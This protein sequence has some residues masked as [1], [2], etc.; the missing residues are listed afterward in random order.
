MKRHRNLAPAPVAVV[1]STILSASCPSPRAGVSRNRV[2]GISEAVPIERAL[3]YVADGRG[4]IAS[5]AA[6]GAT[7]N[8]LGGTGE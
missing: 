1:T 3:V 8:L 7:G 6:L 2:K 4:T 5:A